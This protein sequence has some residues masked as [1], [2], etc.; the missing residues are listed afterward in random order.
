[1]YS[2]Y[3]RSR[4]YNMPSHKGTNNRDAYVLRYEKEKM[5]MY[6]GTNNR[7]AYLPRYE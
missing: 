4:T 7:D 1:M 6:Y 2:T 3:D 5:I